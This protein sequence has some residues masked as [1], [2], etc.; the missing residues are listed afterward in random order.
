MDDLIFEIELDEG[1]KDYLTNNKKNKKKSDI[2]PKMKK[3]Y[4]NLNDFLKNKKVSKNKD[5]DKKYFNIKRQYLE[6]LN[7]KFDFIKYIKKTDP[8]SIKN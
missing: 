1:T 8:I 2:K 5:I 6:K 4:L 7:I 3:N